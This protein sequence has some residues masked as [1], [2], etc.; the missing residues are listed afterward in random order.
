MLLYVI[1]HAWAE[2]YG[3]PDWPDDAERPLTAEGKKRFA[4]IVKSLASRS[5]APELIATSPLVR[6]RQTAELVVKGLKGKPKLVE[7]EELRPGSNLDV[8]LAWT[9]QEAGEHKELAW[10]GHSPD[11]ENLA[12]ALIGDPGAHIRFSK[13][14]IAAIEFPALPGLREGELRWLVTAKVL[15]V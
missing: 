7:R 5:F 15:G 12:T 6:C 4:D 11:V 1:R 3:Y 13:G 10:V 14:A 8:L 2:P 9:A